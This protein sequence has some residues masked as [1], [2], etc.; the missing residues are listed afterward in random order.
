M[1]NVNK[2]IKVLKNFISVFLIKFGFKK[3]YSKTQIETLNNL[4][5]LVVSPGGVGTT[6]L[7]DHI[8]N[9]KKINDRD[10]ADGLKHKFKPYNGKVDALKIIYIFGNYKSIYKS[11]KRREYF[12]TQMLHFESIL[13]TLSS[14]LISLN[15]FKK[16]AIAHKKNWMEAGNIEIL[17]IDYEDLFE[18][19]MEIKKF[20]NISEKD[21][22]V[23]FPIRKTRLS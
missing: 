8:S 10:N 5:V 2:L 7:I 9:F 18:S 22:L 20:L 6:V 16:L 3:R 1:L 11:L 12:Q 14:K 4:D 15:Y 17:F 21:F 19:K 23:N 13:G